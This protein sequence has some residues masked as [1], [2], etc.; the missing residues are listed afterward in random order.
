MGVPLMAIVPLTFPDGAAEQT[1]TVTLLDDPGAEGSET[2]TIT[3]NN[4][5]GVA[6]LGE[7]STTTVTILDNETASFVYLPL[8]QR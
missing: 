4:V 7:P 6:T 8:V 5:V 2:F 1:F 3:L